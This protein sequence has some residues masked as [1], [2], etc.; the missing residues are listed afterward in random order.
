MSRLR[1]ALAAVAVAA[2]AVPTLGS[3]AQAG[4]RHHDA[5]S[6]DS[7]R[8]SAPIVSGLVGPLG[9]A[10]QANGD[11]YVAETFAGRLTEVTG[12]D[13][14]RVVANAPGITGVSSSRNGVVFTSSDKPD[15]ATTNASQ[16]RLLRRAGLSTPVG[17]IW[18]FERLVNPDRVNSYG[19]QNLSRAC[20]LQ[21]P[22]D[23]R[24]YRGILDS[25]AYKVAELGRN[26]YVVADAG[27]NDILQVRN[28]RVSLVAVLPPIPSRVTPAVRAAFN[29]PLCT[30]GKIFNFEP[31]PTDV[32]VGSDGW[33][34][35]SSLPGGPEGMEGAVLGARGAV[36]KVHP[37]RGT[38]QRVATG[39][40]GAVDIALDGRTI[41]V[42]EMFG[43]KISRVVGSRG[44]TVVNVNTPGAIEWAR[45]KLYATIDVLPPETGAPNGKLVTIEQARLFQPDRHRR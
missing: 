40:S 13:R 4:G 14:S 30:L 1:T 22:A 45:G 31:V 32:E 33:L 10:V 27:G 38:V 2:L 8:V 34:Y 16:L 25:H 43:N 37:N 17:D 29:L 41:Y 7:W 23:M 5:P 26:N 35:V 19:F 11:A 3:P 18:R 42:A 12:R 44:V 28:G 24:S 21:V 39:F 20:S 36:F 6:R 9:L 15:Q